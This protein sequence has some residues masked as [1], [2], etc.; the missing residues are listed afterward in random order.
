MVAT[1]T[2]GNEVALEFKELGNKEFKSGSYLKAAG[3]Y[4]K[5]IKA[6]PSN[7]V[8]YSNRCA[9]LLQLS[10]VTKALADAE[11][12]ISLKPTWGKVIMTCFRHC[13]VVPWS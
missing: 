1:T 6:D 7:H 8:L 9:A 10:K 2:A 12:A 13:Y 11:T 5:A 4:S 3:L